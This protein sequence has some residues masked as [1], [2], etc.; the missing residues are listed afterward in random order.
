MGQ[1]QPVVD[2]LLISN[3]RCLISKNLMGH[4]KRLVAFHCILFNRMVINF[5]NWQ[6]LSITAASA[7]KLRTSAAAKTGNISHLWHERQKMEKCPSTC[8]S[9]SVSIIGPIIYRHQYL[10]GIAMRKDDSSGAVKKCHS[11]RIVSYSAE[12]YRWLVNK[13]K[14]SVKRGGRT[15][16]MTIGPNVWKND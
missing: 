3:F 4:S 10:I 11:V 1:T 16:W 2:S 5:C 14:L 9:I 6:K 13:Q 7:M 12:L 15:L 8:Q